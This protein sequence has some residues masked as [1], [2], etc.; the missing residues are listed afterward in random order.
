MPLNLS[1]SSNALTKPSLTTRHTRVPWTKAGLE[2]SIPTQ[3]SGRQ[4]VFV[5][6]VVAAALEPC[7]WFYTRYFV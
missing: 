6:S 4:G 5:L 2:Q 3:H 7:Q 1:W